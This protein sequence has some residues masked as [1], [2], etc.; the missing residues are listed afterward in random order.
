[1]TISFKKFLI[2]LASFGLGILTFQLLVIW[3]FGIARGDSFGGEII[4]MYPI[5]LATMFVYYFLIK[6]LFRIQ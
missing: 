1:M 4:F 5:A 2:G 6:K 3:D